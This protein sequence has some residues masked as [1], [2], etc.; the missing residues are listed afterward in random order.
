MYKVIGDALKEAGLSET[1]HPQDYL[2]FYCLGK[3]EPL[4]KQTQSSNASQENAP[5][6]CLTHL[7]FSYIY[8]YFADD[9]S[10]EISIS[11][12][13]AASVSEIP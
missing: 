10:L 8:I 13:A 3:C 7:T 12:L 6:V 4:L 1:K 5:Q 9:R 2:N 11:N